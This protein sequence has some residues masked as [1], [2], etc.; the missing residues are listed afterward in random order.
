MSTPINQVVALKFE[1][2]FFLITLTS[3]CIAYDKS[4]YLL[5]DFSG[6]PLCSRVHPLPYNPARHPDF[7]QAAIAF[8]L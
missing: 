7:E 8:G 3:S 6:F 1:L 5:D 4:S 2:I